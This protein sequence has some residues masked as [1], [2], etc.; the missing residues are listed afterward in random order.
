MKTTVT[1]LCEAIK[2]RKWR[3]TKYGC[4]R[5]GYSD[6]GTGNCPLVAC[7]L[8]L[9]PKE[10]RGK[11]G[12]SG[13]EYYDVAADAI[14]YVGEWGEFIE[15]VDDTVEEMHNKTFYTGSDVENKRKTTRQIRLRKKMFKL[16]G[17]DMAKI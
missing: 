1:A 16:L 4:I 6:H 17:L 15:A 14:G 7:A 3:V 5:N 12:K 9:A 8:E 2:D 11:G 13:Q 10:F